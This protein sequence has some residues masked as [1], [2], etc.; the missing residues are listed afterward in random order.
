MKTKR[1]PRVLSILLTM[2]MLLSVLTMS[3]F[4]SNF[5]GSYGPSVGSIEITGAT[6]LSGTTPTVTPYTYAGYNCNRYTYNI[7]L[8]NATALNATVTA[9]FTK[10]GS[11]SPNCIISPVPPNQSPG[12]V[13]ANAKLNYATTLSS[14]AGTVTAYVHHNLATQRGNCD[15]Y[16]FNYTVATINNP[17]EVGTGNAITLRF[18]DPV[19]PNTKPESLMSFEYVSG[20]TYDA[21]YTGADSAD[22]YPSVLT[23]LATPDTEIDR[24]VGSGVQI[25]TYDTLGNKTLHSS[26]IPANNINN[27]VPSDLYTLE[28]GTLGGTLTIYEEDGVTVAA[29]INFDAPKSLPAA[30]GAKPT[31]VNG[32]LPV[33]QFA[34][35]SG[36][37]AIGTSSNSL[38]S[39]KFV[40]GYT[41]TGVSLGML[42]GYVQFDM[43]T[44]PITN[45]VKNPYGVDFIIYGN[46][47]DGNPEA[48]SVQ[49]SEDGITWYELAGSRYYDS[50]TTRNITVTYINM[51]AANMG[52]NGAFTSAGVYASRNYTGSISGATWTRMGV[53]GWWPEYGSPEYYGNVYNDGAVKTTTNT[54]YAVWSTVSGYN[55]ITYKNVTEVPDSNLNGFYQFGYFDVTANG[56]SYGNAVNPYATYISTKTGG[57][58]F[59]LSWA[60]DANGEPVELT[61]VRY[62]RAYSS[63]LFNAGIFGET[64]AEV[65]GMYVAVPAGSAVGTTTEPAITI[66]GD[67]IYNYAPVV[68]TVGNVVVY[69]VSALGLG[70]GTVIGATAPTGTNVYVNNEF[71]GTVT[72]TG[73]TEYVRVIAQTGNSEPYIALIKIA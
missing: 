28:I 57:D 38:S 17:I 4:A 15:T 72:T 25:A 33:G 3:A 12:V 14:G 65:C 30:G 62:V 43:D 9:T 2:A 60:V 7:V 21:E 18:G 23:L 71:A 39:P 8:S 63:V 41:A 52:L 69:D 11:A 27:G 45:N 26:I 49:V 66:D 20:S 61:S 16:I 13:V 31:A 42:G 36:W 51:P 58:G 55:L 40:G 59:D 37:G 67:D 44:T 19:Y 54:P 10:S 1:M 24:L 29:I 46:A 32:Y 47:F 70:S 35:G 56:T 6:V 34:T 22:F 50:G 5:L 53:V 73:T 48:G 64:S 68:T